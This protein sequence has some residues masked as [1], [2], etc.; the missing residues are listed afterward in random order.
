MGG[1]IA[2]GRRR[3]D[4]CFVDLALTFVTSREFSKP[5]TAAAL[6]ASPS[7]QWTA[8]F[9]FDAPWYLAGHNPGAAVW[10]PRNSHRRR[11]ARRVVYARGRGVHLGSNAATRKWGNTESV[12]TFTSTS[13]S[14]P[15]DSPCLPCPAP[16]WTRDAWRGADTK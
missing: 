14:G 15:T 5:P 3:G 1:S 2:A 6:H 7:N 12:W 13:S 10:V 8:R 16:R 4:A 9:G 11:P